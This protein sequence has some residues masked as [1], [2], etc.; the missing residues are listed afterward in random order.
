MCDFVNINIFFYYVIIKMKNATIFFITPTDRI[1]LVKLRNGH[2][3]TTPGGIIERT[4][5]S[6][7][8]AACREFREE[9]GVSLRNSKITN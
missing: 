4:D 8:Y 3:W 5:P 9:V 6:P 2:K 1:L 7:W